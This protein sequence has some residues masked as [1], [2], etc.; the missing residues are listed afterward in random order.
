M[1]RRLE[2]GEERN[3]LDYFAGAM[4]F[5]AKDKI[6]IPFSYVVISLGTIFGVYQFG[7]RNE[8]SVRSEIRKNQNLE[9]IAYDSYRQRHSPNSW[10]LDEYKKTYL[11]NVRMFM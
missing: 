4:D 7:L 8:D 9:A 11:I 6:L 1:S 10:F 5:L 2:D 3:L